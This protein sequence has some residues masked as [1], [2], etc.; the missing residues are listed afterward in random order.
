MNTIK[1][2]VL[3]TGIVFLFFSCSSTPQ[4][5]V[6][7]FFLHCMDDFYR[8]NPG[9]ATYLRY[10]SGEEQDRLERQSTPLTLEHKKENVELARKGLEE[11]G[12]YDRGRMTDVQ[13]VS[14]EVFEWS[15]NNIIDG[16]PF[17][18]Y[19]FPLNQWNGAN[20][21]L[22]NM[23]VRGRSLGTER[24]AENYVAVLGQV[25]TR[26]DEA[27]EEARRIAEKGII[28]PKFIIQSTIDQMQ[29]FISSEPSQNPFVVTF[30]QKMSSIESLPDDKRSQLQSTAEKIVAEQVYPAWKRGISLLESQKEEATD[31]AGLWRFKGGDE[32]YRFALR[33]NTTTDLTPDQIHKIGLKRVQEIEVRMD[34]LLRQL[35]R[36]EGSLNDRIAKLK[37]DL[38]Y[39][40]PTS[41]ESREKI[42][43]DIDNIVRDAEKRAALIFD[44]MP[45]SPVIVQPTPSFQEVSDSARYN[46]PAMDGSRTAIFL[47]PRRLSR[48][49]SFGMRTTVYHETVPGHHFQIALQMEN[50]ELPRFR[51]AFAPINSFIEGWALYAEKLAAESGW[52]EG[53]I[54]G[55]LGQ[56]YWELFRARRLV[57]DT[58]LHAKRWTRQQAIDYGVDESEADRY[59]M[60]PGQACAYMIGQIKLLELRDKAKQAL[61]E[62]FSI[63][64][65]HNLLL[66]N[67]AVPLNVLEKLVDDYIKSERAKVAER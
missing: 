29:L 65:F 3:A 27:I 39:P 51:Q 35:G 42:I 24:D 53:D 52:Y 62:Q 36:T 2:V 1:L 18:D 33:S 37:E 15:M 66:G 67:G 11:L 45:K 16:E 13:R 8:H 12:K 26:M 63:K 61:G 6:D 31:D 9:Y 60:R 17:L 58:G 50:Q 22:V 28:P 59:I 5:N 32:A 38:G 30:L 40:N 64:D 55:I 56:L 41:E 43:K 21:N 14:A 10:F 7:D 25:E 19:A 49:N 20:V 34:D 54:E 4:Q 23:L 48:M 44:K 46:P 47:Y 57:V